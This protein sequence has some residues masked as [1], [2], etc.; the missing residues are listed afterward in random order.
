MIGLSSG[1]S[2][3]DGIVVSMS[4]LVEHGRTR[5]L[6]QRE[7]PVCGASRGSNFGGANKMLEIDPNPRRNSK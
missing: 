4:L 1:V 7:I 3:S 6:W 5:R 2:G